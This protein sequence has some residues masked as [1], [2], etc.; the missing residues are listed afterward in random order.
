ME[1]NEAGANNEAGTI[2]LTRLPGDLKSAH[3]DNPITPNG[4]V[5]FATRLSTPVVK[6]RAA[7]YKIGL[8]GFIAS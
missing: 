6:S 1:I 2:N 8:I 3:A 7:D 5:P 4:K